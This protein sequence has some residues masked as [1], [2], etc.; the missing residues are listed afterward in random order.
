MFKDDYLRKLAIAD[1]LSE[2]KMLYNR[3]KLAETKD[4]KVQCENL[5]DKELMDLFILLTVH[6]SGQGELKAKRVAR[7]KEKMEN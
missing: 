4:R 6:F 5:W 3:Y 7:F 2:C 1:H